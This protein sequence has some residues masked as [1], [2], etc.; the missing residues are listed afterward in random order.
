MERIDTTL[1]LESNPPNE[2]YMNMLLR[3]LESDNGIL[4]MTILPNWGYDFLMPPTGMVIEYNADAAFKADVFFTDMWSSTSLTRVECVDESALDNSQDNVLKALQMRTDE[5]PLF[6]QSDKKNWNPTM[7]DRN[8]TI[9]LYSAN[10]MNPKTQMI[11][12]T[13]FIITKTGIDPGTY[14]DMEKY[15]LMCEQEGKTIKDVFLNNPIIE[16]FQ[17]LIIR[18]RRRIIHDFAQAAGISIRSRQYNKGTKPMHIANEE[19]VT[20][21]NYVKFTEND[22]KM[23]FYANATST[24]DVHHGLIFHRAPLQGPLIYV[25]PTARQGTALFQGNK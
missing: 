6:Q 24:D 17:A 22:A 12:Q 5:P 4:K 13:W 16:Q 11:E 7:S 19:F 10:R 1:T 8:A 18:N 23:L 25:G 15:F 3:V 9:G 2:N 14:T 21:N 20:P